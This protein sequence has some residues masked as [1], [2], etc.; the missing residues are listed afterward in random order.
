MQNDNYDVALHRWGPDYADPQTYMDLFVTGASNNYGHYES[1]KYDSLIE[2]ALTTDAA[3]S[4]KR[5]EDFAEAEKVLVNEDTAIIPLYQAGNTA[6]QNT[7]LT[8]I[9]Y[10]GAGVD[11]YRHMK[12]AA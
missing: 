8:G 3:D 7:K 5:W 4:T 2:K 10:H 12:L 11:S 1:E 6:L 9:Q